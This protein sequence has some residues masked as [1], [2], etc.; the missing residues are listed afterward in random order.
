MD[1]CAAR[2]PL[3]PFRESR[4]RAR[5]AISRARCDVGRNSLQ[6]RQGRIIAST[7]GEVRVEVADLRS[8]RTSVL[9]RL[10][11]APVAA[12]RRRRARASRRI[13]TFPRAR[14]DIRRHA[15]ADRLDREHHP[16]YQPGTLE[17]LS[18]SLPFHLAWPPSRSAAA[19]YGPFAPAARCLEIELV[20]FSFVKSGGR[21]Y[22]RCANLHRSRGFRPDRGAPCPL[23]RAI[24]APAYR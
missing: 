5:S 21:E 9:A 7:A 23:V 15:A 11:N 12:T 8:Q 22:F 10:V 20:M 18:E 17:D 1:G 24:T 4:S 16:P 14:A 6:T 13:R 2:P 3:P 19:R